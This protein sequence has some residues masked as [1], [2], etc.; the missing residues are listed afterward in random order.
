LDYN[1]ILEV[2]LVS[3][4]DFLK[5]PLRTFACAQRTSLTLRTSLRMKAAAKSPELH[6]KLSIVLR[7]VLFIPETYI[8]NNKNVSQ[9]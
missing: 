8:E 2:A 9:I 7:E 5:L 1:L 6:W 4:D 3:G